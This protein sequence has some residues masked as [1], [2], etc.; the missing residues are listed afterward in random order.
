M[1][2]GQAFEPTSGL[3]AG[4]LH[5]LGSEAIFHFGW[6]AIQH[7]GEIFAHPREVLLHP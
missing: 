5:G 3:P 6:D 7:P 2:Q 1:R 4:A